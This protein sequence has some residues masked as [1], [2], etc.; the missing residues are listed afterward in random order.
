METRGIFA[1]ISPLDHRYSV[2]DPSLFAALSAILS[3][4]S[5]IGYCVRVECA[6]VRAL[7]AHGVGPAL[8][9]AEEAALDALE[10]AITPDEVYA[11]ELKTQHNVRALVNGLQKNI[12][13]GF[14]FRAGRALAS[15]GAMLAAHVLP[16]AAP[17]VTPSPARWLFAA[18]AL[19][20]ALQ[21]GLA[22]RSAG[23]PFR[24]GPLF[25]VAA[26]VWAWIVVRGTIVP[27]AR[28]E[29][30]WRGTRYRLAEL[31][32]SGWRG[33]GPGVRSS[34]PEGASDSPGGRRTDEGDR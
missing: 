25:P 26:L 20:L 31:R 5:A 8:S 3:E 6:L 30:E 21:V 19:L 28:G 32:T 4:E 13:S 29:I 7:A 34:Q 15:A 22:G 11:E 16:F 17:F 33:R 10:A 18:A 24:S 2:S 9:P 27:L 23:L 1:N 12:F 14:D